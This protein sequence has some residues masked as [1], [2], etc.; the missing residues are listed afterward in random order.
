MLRVSWIV[1]C[2]MQELR[3]DM[4][5]QISLEKPS[6]R[7]ADI[8]HIDQK[9]IVAMWSVELVI[10]DGIV[11]VEPQTLCDLSLLFYGEEDVALD[12]NDEGGD[13]RESGQASSECGDVSVRGGRA[14]RADVLPFSGSWCGRSI[15]VD[16]EVVRVL[17][18]V[19]ARA[20]SL[21]VGKSVVR[22]I[23][24]IHR[25]GDVDERIGVVLE[26]ELFTL[27]VQVGFDEKVRTQRW[28]HLFVVLSLGSHSTRSTE[29]LLPLGSGSIGEGGYLS[30]Q[31]HSC[32]RR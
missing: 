10:P 7:T 9:A 13:V 1:V 19:R 21:Q 15:G 22:H 2:T 17:L 27:V 25:L 30:S 18:A 12:A 23:E 20:P 6:N 4:L 31:F 26:A 16:G 3:G 24:Q 14:E 5:A 29:T 11:A 32:V 28:S 8:G